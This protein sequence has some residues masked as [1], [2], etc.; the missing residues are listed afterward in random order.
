MQSGR[1]KLNSAGKYGS[2]RWVCK[3]TYQ[4]TC[5]PRT[6]GIQPLVNLCAHL[7]V[8][9]L[10]AAIAYQRLQHARQGAIIAPCRATAETR[11]K[12]VFIAYH[13][14]AYFLIVYFFLLWGSWVSYCSQSPGAIIAPQQ[15]SVL[16]RS[17]LEEEKQC[18][19]P[20]NRKREAH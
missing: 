6:L 11:C 4:N 18:K 7:V 9:G 13:L 16:K 5:V 12:S 3:Q 2:C 1:I 15:E 14:V 17:L 8:L 19:N 20:W 10:L